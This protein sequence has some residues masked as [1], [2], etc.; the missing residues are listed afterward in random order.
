MVL[1][2]QAWRAW[3]KRLGNRSTPGKTTRKNILQGMG[4]E[5]SFMNYDIIKDR[6]KDLYRDK[7]IYSYNYE[8]VI[9]GQTY[10][11]FYGIKLNC[12]KENKSI[13]YDTNKDGEVGGDDDNL[14]AQTFTTGSSY[15]YLSKI[16]VFNN[17]SG[18][19]N[20]TDNIYLTEIDGNGKPD[21]NNIIR[22][23]TLETP[24]SAGEWLDFNCSG[25]ILKPNTTY[26][27]IEVLSEGTT[28]T[29]WEV[30]ET[31]PT[32]T[33]GSLFT[34]SDAGVNWTEDTT[35]DAMFRI[36][37]IDFN[38][39]NIFPASGVYSLD[40]TTTFSSLVLTADQ[41]FNTINFDYDVNY[42]MAVE[43]LALLLL[44]H[45][46][47][48]LALYFKISILKISQDGTETEIASSTINEEEATAVQ[49]NQMIGIK[50]EQ[51][52]TIKRGDKLRLKLELLSSG[53][54][55]STYVLDHDQGNFALK[56]PTKF[57]GNIE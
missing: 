17:K 57:I 5:K 31:S 20:P 1:G 32:Y 24:S 10:L 43:G 46:I 35:K 49:T 14:V 33:G 44:T 42:T 18:T 11:D 34:S 12:S 54:G 28:D 55:S 13:Y 40:E 51:I 19:G 36:Y 37:T 52:Q 56:L 26:A 47:T 29:F 30:D 16:S 9:K 25:I 48:N 45:T 50:I 21:L 4:L 39:Y 7:T 6:A 22:T 23:D 8:D 2:P 3:D 38:N 41:T 53:T 27:I 15:I